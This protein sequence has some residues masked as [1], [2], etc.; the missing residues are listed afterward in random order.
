MSL[1]TKKGFFCKEQARQEDV[2]LCMLSL[3]DWNLNPHL[4][5]L[6]SLL[7]KYVNF[8]LETLQH[9]NWIKL[10]HLVWRI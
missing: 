6:K 2:I 8:K 7:Q 5:A 1:D 9:T 3:T 4:S 10:N